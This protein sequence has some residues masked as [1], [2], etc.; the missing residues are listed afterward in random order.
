M[1]PKILH[2]A[3]F[4]SILDHLDWIEFLSIWRPLS[5]EVAYCASI[6]LRE[7]QA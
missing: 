7:E 3:P 5:Q 1:R 4:I 6:C 2:D